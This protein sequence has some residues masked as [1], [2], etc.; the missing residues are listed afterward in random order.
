MRVVPLH[1]R[2]VVRHA[3]GVHGGRPEHRRVAERQHLGA[4]L[5]AAGI[6][7]QDVVAFALIGRV[8]HDVPE[9]VAAED[10]V[11]RASL[12]VDPPDGLALVVI[13]GRLVG[14]LAAGVRRG[15]QQR[16]QSQGGGAIERRIDAVVDEAAAQVDLSAA[17]TGG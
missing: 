7:F 9:H 14:D 3:D 16:H 17:V 13:F 5:E 6:G 8:L 2:A 12:V 1:P 4:I 10:G 15:R 11:V